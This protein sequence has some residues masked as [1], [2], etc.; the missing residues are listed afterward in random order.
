MVSVLSLQP[1]T[2]LTN[3]FYQ[4]L[5]RTKFADLYIIRTMYKYFIVPNFVVPCMELYK[6]I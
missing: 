1:C 3:S 2:E 5:N 4:L 6:L